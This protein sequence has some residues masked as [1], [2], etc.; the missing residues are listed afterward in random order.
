[1]RK[2]MTQRSL[3]RSLAAAVLC[4]VA[5]CADLGAIKAYP[6]G[7]R[8]K[9]EIGIIETSA[10]SEHF[11]VVEDRITAVDGMRYEKGGYEAHMLPGAHRIGLQ[12]TLRTNPQMR[13]QYCSFGLQVQAGCSYRPTIPSYPRVQLGAPADAEWRLTRA[14]TVLS[15]CA[16]TS[17]AFDVPID[18]SSQP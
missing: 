12:S 8:G 10:R 6:G 14:M 11:F 9:A 15:Q 7:S 2:G 1:M 17:F 16:D 18:C 3:R 13:V 5:G 4:A